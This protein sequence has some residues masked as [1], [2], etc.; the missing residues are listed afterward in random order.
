MN[1]TYIAVFGPLQAPPGHIGFGL[2]QRTAGQISWKMQIF[3]ER[4]RCPSQN[5]LACRQPLGQADVKSEGHVWGGGAGVVKLKL[6]QQYYVSSAFLGP[7]RHSRI[8]NL[9]PPFIVQQLISIM[10]QHQFQP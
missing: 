2:L 6:K 9:F 10:E 1:P 3:F 4:L 5:G 7:Q 8:F